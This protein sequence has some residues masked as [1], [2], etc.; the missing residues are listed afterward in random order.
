[1]SL[2]ELLR[3]ADLIS[4]HLS[5]TDQ[6]RHIIN[7]ESLALM[8]D[9]ALLVNAARGA[10]VDAQALASALNEGRL[11]GA[12]LDVFEPE[13]PPDDSPLRTTRNILLTSHTAWYS[14]ESV[15]DARIESVD[16]I[17]EFLGAS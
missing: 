12:G 6:T 2:E 14:E 7:D 3:T 5:S 16:S 15:A 4:M 17:I 13:I 8:K 10:L 9:T 11:G 1:M